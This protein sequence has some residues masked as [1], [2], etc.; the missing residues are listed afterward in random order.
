MGNR[1][2]VEHLSEIFERVVPQ[3]AGKISIKMILPEKTLIA[4][5]EVEKE[6]D[7]NF[8]SGFAEYTDEPFDYEWKVKTD[9]NDFE[10]ISSENLNIA[11]GQGIGVLIIDQF[12]LHMKLYRDKSSRGIGLLPCKFYSQ[13]R[14][15]KEDS[16]SLDLGIGYN[17]FW[18]QG[19]IYHDLVDEKALEEAKN[20]R[21]KNLVWL[22]GLD[23]K[24]SQYEE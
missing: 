3:S 23:P 9:M 20:K 19:D 7:T 17:I 11:R 16:V 8:L 22:P 24:L 15:E 1:V 21:G 13:T 5:F 10:V 6:R 14:Q 18:I 4:V 2:S 12:N